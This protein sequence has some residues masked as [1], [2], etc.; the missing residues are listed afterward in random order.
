M[1]LIGFDD[2]D[3]REG[4]CTTYLAYRVVDFL[5]SLSDVKVLDYPLLVRLNPNIP[6]KTRGNGALC[7][8]V[9]VNNE[10]TLE[11]IKRSI[12]NML[13]DESCINSGANPALVFYEC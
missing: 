9:Q 5:L 7:I 12:L 13:I 8:K 6:W 10:S 1:L 11:Y 4:K 2:T 3:S